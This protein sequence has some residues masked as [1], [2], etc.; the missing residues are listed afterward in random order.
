M[1]AD[2]PYWSGRRDPDVLQCQ[3]QLLS[4]DMFPVAATVMAESQLDC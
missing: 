4:S 2:K 1:L 3:A